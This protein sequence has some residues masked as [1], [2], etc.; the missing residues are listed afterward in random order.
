MAGDFS[1]GTIDGGTVVH[2]R[3]LN[4]QNH[5]PVPRAFNRL[6]SFGDER[7]E[8]LGYVTTNSTLPYGSCRIIVIV[9]H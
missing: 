8:L 9:K 6:L 5:S 4:C 3:Q 2:K 7:A 1:H